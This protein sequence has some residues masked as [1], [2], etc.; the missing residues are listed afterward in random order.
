MRLLLPAV[1]LAALVP[2]TAHADLLS[3]RAEAHA[4]GGGG[5]GVAGDQ[6]DH[7]FQKGARGAEYGALVGVEVLFVDVWIQHHQFATG[8]GLV[9]TWTQFMTGMDVDVD[10]G[11][12]PEVK[13]QERGRPSGYFEA[14]LGLGFGVG[15][16]QQVMLPLDNAQV[17]D[18]GFLAEA[19]I[20]AGKNLGPI[21]SIGLLGTVSGGYYFKSGPGIVANDTGTHYQAVEAS[22]L[23][24]LRIK[25]KL[26]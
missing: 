11:V 18:K 12:P 21:L 8:D 9:G 3:F 24:N 1:V 4:G 2:A 13:G 19:K 26:K 20:G 5:A 23:I 14:G 6:Q 15:T 7:A 17:T 10:L 16:G 25:L 22:A